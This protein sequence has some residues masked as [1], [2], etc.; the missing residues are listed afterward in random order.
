MNAGNFQGAGTDAFL[1]IH[2]AVFCAGLVPID[3]VELARGRSQPGGE[4]RR[5]VRP[6]PQ[7]R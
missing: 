4:K 5:H 3:G 6:L 2:G 1:D 7:R